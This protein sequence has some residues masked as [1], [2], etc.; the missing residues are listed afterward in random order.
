VKRILG[1]AEDYRRL[2]GGGLLAPGSL[3]D[4]PPYKKIRV[5]SKPKTA[6]KPAVVRTSARRTKKSKTTGTN[7]TR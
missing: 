5:V 4:A 6:K 3:K 7:K 1:T 2:Y